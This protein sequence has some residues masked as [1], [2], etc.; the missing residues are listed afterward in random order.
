M[1]VEG[2]PLADKRVGSRVKQELEKWR[3]AA[4]GEAILHVVLAVADA[5]D[6][7]QEERARAGVTGRVIEVDRFVR[8]RRYDRPSVGSLN[9]KPLKTSDQSQK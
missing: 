8:L 4:I 5:R 3:H 7:R 6:E 2:D 1:D 9:N